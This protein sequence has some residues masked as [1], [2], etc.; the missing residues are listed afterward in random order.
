[1]PDMIMSLRA[2]FARETPQA[3]Q[4][5]SKG[6]ATHS[7]KPQVIM[8]KNSLSGDRRHTHKVG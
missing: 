3:L 6:G 1:M 5:S 4:R 2:A 8:A 7:H